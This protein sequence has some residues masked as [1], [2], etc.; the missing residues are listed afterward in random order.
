VH[1]VD[2]SSG[3][4]RDPAEDL[5]TIRRELQLFQPDL[6]QRRQIVAANKI[7][8]LDDPTRL[9]RLAARAV[10]LSIRLVPISAVTG[11]G[12]ATL[13]EEIWRRLVE[14]RS[15]GASNLPAHPGEPATAERRGVL[16]PS[17]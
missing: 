13:L 14:E 4:G 17:E 15:A 6:L 16:F 9:A 10:A 12:V 8:V 1:V 5:E 2:I 11:E 3:S 7:D